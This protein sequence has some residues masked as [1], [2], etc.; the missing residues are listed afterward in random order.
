VVVAVGLDRERCSAPLLTTAADH[1]HAAVRRV[2]QIGNRHPEHRGRL[3]L[4]D[5]VDR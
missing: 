5:D 1:R 2:E 4:V 3:V